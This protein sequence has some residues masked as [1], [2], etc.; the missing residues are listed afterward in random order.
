M[1]LKSKWV[2]VLKFKNALFFLTGLFFTIMSVWDVV[3]LIVYYFGKWDTVLHARSTPE[4]VVLF[5]VGCI[6]LIYMKISAEAIKKA[7]F[8]SS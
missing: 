2:T 5:I 6:M 4:S 1:Y 3:S 7:H 8:Y